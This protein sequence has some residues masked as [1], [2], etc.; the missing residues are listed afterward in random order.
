MSVMRT[1][2]NKSSSQ[3]LGA[4]VFGLRASRVLGIGSTSER[5]GTGAY[6]RGG[7][8]VMESLLQVSRGTPLLAMLVFHEVASMSMHGCGHQNFSELRCESYYESWL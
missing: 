2:G 4:R 8:S 3:K 1:E 5:F 7:A 6:V